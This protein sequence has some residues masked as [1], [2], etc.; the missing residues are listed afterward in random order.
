DSGFD[1][2]HSDLA[3]NAYVNLAELEGEPGV[4]DDGNGYIDDIHGINTI[5]ETG[6]P[7]PYDGDEHGTHVA[8]TIAAAGNNGTGVVGVNWE[9]KIVACKAFSLFATLEDI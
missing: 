5:D 3:A 2:L 4:D 1:Y 9:A 7:F 6:D 8:G